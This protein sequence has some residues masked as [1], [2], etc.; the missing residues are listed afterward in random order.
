MG[1]ATTAHKHARCSRRSWRCRWAQRK[2]QRTHQQPPHSW[3]DCWPLFLSLLRRPPAVHQHCSATSPPPASRGLPFAPTAP[4]A[5]PPR[6]STRAK[7][8]FCHTTWGGL[9]GLDVFWSYVL[10]QT[11]VRKNGNDLEDK[12]CFE[13]CKGQVEACEWNRLTPHH[14][15]VGLVPQP[16]PGKIL[17][18]TEILARVPAC[19]RFLH[20]L[21][22]HLRLPLS[23]DGHLLRR[24]CLVVP[25]ETEALRHC[26]TA[27]PSFFR[28]VP[29]PLTSLSPCRNG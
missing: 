11:L 14:C 1:E 22:P 10:V 28:V 20:V 16:L 3:L 19:A 21:L 9:G 25:V 24:L 2:N 5:P 23:Q 7:R 15:S 13:V 26:N 6:Q 18:K 27:A 17:F 12:D 29:T 4:A 8:A